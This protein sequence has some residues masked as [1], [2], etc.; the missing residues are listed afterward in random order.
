M[1]P[2]NDDTLR[3]RRCARP[4]YLT[5]GH[6]RAVL[7]VHGYTGY[8]GELAYP[9][10]MMADAGWDVR[11]PRL[12]GHGTSG[13]DFTRT[14]ISMWRRQVADEWLN[15]KSVYDEVAVIGHSMGGLLT[16]DLATYFPVSSTIVMAPAIGVRFRGQFFL[17][18]I[19]LFLR[20]WPIERN[21]DP[22]YRFFDDRDEDDDRYLGSEYWSWIW[23]KH[24]ANLLRLQTRTEKRLKLIS[25]SVLG[26]HGEFDSVTGG[27]SRGL[28]KNKLG[29]RY[30]EH[31]LPGCGH[32]IPYDP[33]PGSKEKAMEIIINWL[34]GR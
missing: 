21:Q 22:S 4:L 5:G 11:V 31:V 1:K 28:L 16:L 19:S 14:H 34:E 8:P 10:R 18:P 29:N 3:V 12:T 9:A 30:T 15:M 24:L 17:K 6:R 7:M 33:N 2:A 20:K 27:G 26:I 32:Y 23:F 13:G 25:G